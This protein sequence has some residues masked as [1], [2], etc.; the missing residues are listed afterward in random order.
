[1]DHLLQHMKDHDSV[2]VFDIVY[3]MRKERHLWMVQTEDQYL[4]IHQCVLAAINQNSAD[5]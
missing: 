5:S 3:E 4:L 2:D 1:V